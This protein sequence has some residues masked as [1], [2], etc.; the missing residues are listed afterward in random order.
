VAESGRRVDALAAAVKELPPRG[1]IARG[2][3]RSYGDSAQNGGG[4]VLRLHDQVLDAAIDEA[5]GTVTVP[6]GVSLDDLL[7][8]AVPRGFFVPV[9]PGTRFV[10]IGG[11]IASD[12][13]Q[14]HHVEGSFGKHVQRCPRGRRLGRR[15]PDSPTFWATVGGMGLTGV[16]LDATVR[17]TSRPVG[18]G[19]LTRTRP[20][21][22]ARPHGTTATATRW[23][24]STSWPRAHSAGAS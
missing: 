3:G 23:P 21:H 1:G 10:T 9:S 16:I 11:A 22:P 19:R 7:R 15:L 18:V 4:V 6:A 8:V 12:I 14:N 2:L 20:R 13:R 24:G 17:L 5:A